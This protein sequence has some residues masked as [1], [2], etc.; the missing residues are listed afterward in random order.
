M[1]D[2]QR[3]RQS[4]RQREKQAPCRD[5]N[6]GLDPRSPGSHPG[7]K[8][9]AQPLNH[10]GVPWLVNFFNKISLVITEIKLNLWIQFVEHC[11]LALKCFL[12]QDDDI[13][14]FI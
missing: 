9:D 12:D 8:A 4:H 14:Q 6:V 2:T 10:P 3:E 5:P 11:H 13:S 1:R 7:P